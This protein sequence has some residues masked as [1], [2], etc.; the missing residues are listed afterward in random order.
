MSSQRLCCMVTLLGNVLLT[1]WSEGDTQPISPLLPGLTPHLVGDTQPIP[2]Y[3][4]ACT[5]PHPEGQQREVNKQVANVLELHTF[6]FESEGWCSVDAG[7][8][9]SIDPPCLPTWARKK[10]WSRIGTRAMRYSTRLATP[11]RSTVPQ[12]ACDKCGTHGTMAA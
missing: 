1:C 6:E 7:W 8:F 11:K 9:R 2:P 5:P 4:L 10:T 12:S 3:Y